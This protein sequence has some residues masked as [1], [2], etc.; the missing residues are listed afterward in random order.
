M[1]PRRFFTGLGVA[2]L[3][4]V[5]AGRAEETRLEATV[6]RARVAPIAPQAAPP[7]WMDYPKVEAGYAFLGKHKATVLHVLATSSLASTFAAKDVAP[8]LMQTGRLSKGFTPRMMSTAAWVDRVFVRPADRE[9]FVANNY[10]QAVALG[11]MHAAVAEA[12]RGPLGWDAKVRVPMSGQA[13]AFVLFSFAWWPVEA[14]LATKEI[15]ATRDASEIDG[16][17]HYWSVIGHGMGVPDELLPRDYARAMELSGLLRQAQYA[18]PSERRPEGL[19]ILLGGQMRMLALQAAL[20]SKIKPAD[21]MP[22]V[23]K[24]FASLLALSPGLIDALGLGH[25]PASRLLEYS[26][27]PIAR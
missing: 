16:W 20:K 11:Q 3:A 14:M 10:A 5:A 12:V 23:A 13:Y 6:R 4:C 17:F 24:D 22:A 15:D 1:T 9:A 26:A 18:P 25:D 21:A 7:A 2:L 8:V 27:Q 19:P